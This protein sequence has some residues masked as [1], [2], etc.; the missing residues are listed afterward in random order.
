M[1][2]FEKASRM[3]LRFS[4]PRGPAGVE[5]MWDLPL[6]TLDAIFKDLNTLLKQSKEESLLEVKT[7]AATAL[8][9]EV[10]IIKHIVSTRLAEMKTRNDAKAT[11]ARKQ[12]L[13]EIIADKQEESLKNMSIEELTKLVDQS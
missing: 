5:D 7:A 9:L 2:M 8:D 12:K 6:P 4:T 13:L 1:S 10:E 3:K 11:A